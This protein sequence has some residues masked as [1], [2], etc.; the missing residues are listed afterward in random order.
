MPERLMLNV[1]DPA[2]GYGRAERRDAA[3]NRTRILTVAREL[4]AAHG[5]AEVNMADIAAAA[6]V[7]KGTLYRR[8]PSKGELAFALLDDDLRAFQRE[9]LETLQGMA[10]ADEPLL[11]QLGWFLERLA[12]FTEQNMSLLREMQGLELGRTHRIDMPH[13]WQYLTVR[14][15]L[16]AAARAGELPAELDVELLAH[17]LLAP[18]A[19]VYFRFLR[20]NRGYTPEEIGTGLRQMV[21][22]LGRELFL[23]A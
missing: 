14:G 23:P 12:N 16:L 4:F 11:Q 1:I 2:A 22:A 21:Q 15:L 9:I 20:L 8:F 6:D 10:A 3:E 18:L 19:P 7:G 13:F 17:A 5:A